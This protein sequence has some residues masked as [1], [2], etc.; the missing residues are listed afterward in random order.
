M[1]TG[2]VFK[3]CDHERPRWDALK[4]RILT[5]GCD[6]LVSANQNN[7]KTPKTSTIIPHNPDQVIC[8]CCIITK[9]TLIAL[10]PKKIRVDLKRLC[11]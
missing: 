3:L 4:K 7:I 1:E 5:E 6:I 11:A 2:E 10:L 8:E 9:R